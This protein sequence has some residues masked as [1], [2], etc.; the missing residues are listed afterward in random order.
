MK[1]RAREEVDEPPV[2]ILQKRGVLRLWERQVPATVQRE[3]RS[4]DHLG[5][6]TSREPDTKT[7]VKK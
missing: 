5:Q 4:S 6:V 7:E 1:G 3:P 2:R